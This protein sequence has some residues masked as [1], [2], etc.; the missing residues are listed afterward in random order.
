[1]KRFVLFSFIGVILAFSA[2]PFGVAA[3]SGI[4]GH[5]TS[6]VLASQGEVNYALGV[7]G[8]SI[9]ALPIATDSATHVTTI[10]NE[11]ETSSRTVNNTTTYSYSYPA[12]NLLFTNATSLEMNDHSVNKVSLNLKIKGNATIDLGLGNLLT[13]TTYSFSP[14]LQNSVSAKNGTANTSFVI[15]A[16]DLTGNGSAVLMLQINFANATENSLYSLSVNMTG[17][18]GSSPWYLAGE[19]AAY[20]FGGG[21]LFIAGFMV[22][23]FHD[24]SI[25]R[26]AQPVIKKQRAKKTA[27]KQ[28]S[29]TKKNPKKGGK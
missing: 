24:F 5:G 12:E 14:I 18:S 6:T 22:L 29:Q 19:S 17:T 20:L 21:I 15:S 8:T 27:K 11:I 2:L 23:P 16:A 10:T 26:M 7:N 25:S 4:S 13:N 9:K 3:A 28:G 1:M